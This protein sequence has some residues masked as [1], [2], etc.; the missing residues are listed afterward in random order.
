MHYYTETRTSKSK[1]TNHTKCCQG[2]WVTKL[3]TLFLEYKIVQPLSKI[4]H[5]Y[6]INKHIL[7]CFNGS[8]PMNISSQ[9]ILYKNVHNSFLYEMTK[10]LETIPFFINR[11]MDIQ[12]LECLYN[13]KLFSRKKQ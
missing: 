11:K 7:Q 9:I 8:M 5:Q 10:K 1:E 3:H 13:G 6:F 12:N 2:Y 4:D